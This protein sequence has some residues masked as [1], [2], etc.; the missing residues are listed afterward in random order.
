MQG[1]HARP[2]Y[3]GYPAAGPVG[4]PGHHHGDA[5]KGFCSG[6]C[7]PAQSCCCGCRECRKEARDLLV[8]PSTSRDQV[9][10]DVGMADAVARMSTL[11]LFANL[12]EDPEPANLAAAGP[13]APNQGRIG[14]GKAFI[15]GG[16]CVHLSIEY[17]PAGA[18][19]GLVAIHVQDSNDTQLIWMKKAV[20]GLGYQIKEGIVTTKPGAH[21][22]LLVVGATARVR[23]CEIFS[24]C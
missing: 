5:R 15:G 16:C 9:V 3:T 24:C 17:T 10:G 20:A 13:L 4:H 11:S 21:L 18:A 8:E 2:M 7:Q 1:T 14:L 23:W 19:D 22:T 6:C 12:K